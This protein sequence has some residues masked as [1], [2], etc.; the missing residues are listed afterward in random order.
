MVNEEE[1]MRRRG[2]WGRNEDEGDEEEE[3]KRGMKR[4]H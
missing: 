4:R 1:E 2:D 3:L